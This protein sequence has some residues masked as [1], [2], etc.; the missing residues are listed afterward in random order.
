MSVLDALLT[1]LISPAYKGIP[2]ASCTL[3]EL[4]RL[5][6]AFWSSTSYSFNRKEAKSHGE[7]GIIV[8]ASLKGK[9]VLVIDDV[10][11]AGTAI[12]ETIDLMAR[13]GA[14]VVAFVVAVD[15]QETMG[16]PGGEGGVGEKDSRKSAMG[17]VR[18]E[19]GIP[20]VS[21]VSLSDLILLMNE[22]G[23]HEK[24]RSMEEYRQR[25]GAND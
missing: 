8:G 23:E 20:A 19:Y 18:A 15:R 17:Q 2:L 21:I 5:D 4:H 22:R 12:R 10:T 3:L 24:A 1:A 11:T 25:H 16:G 13:E 14:T 9:N 7:G 6:P